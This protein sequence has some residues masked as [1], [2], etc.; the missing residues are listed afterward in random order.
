MTKTC[1]KCREVKELNEYNFA[2]KNTGRDGFDS[3]CKECKKLYDQKRNQRKK[4]EISKQKKEYYNKNAKTL[5]EK[6]LNYY[7][8]NKEKCKESNSKWEKENPTKRRL[9]NVKSRTLE[10]GAESTLT[11]TE[12]NEINQYFD[13]SCAYCGITEKES[14]NMY[15]EIL[16]HE[17]VIPLVVGGAYSYGNIVPSCRSCNSSKMN[18]DFYDWYP[19][20]K[21]YNKQREIKIINYIKKSKS[22]Y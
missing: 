12:W 14:L 2:K 22:T 19:N 15:G 20:S 7:S 13:N 18:H 16:H 10:Y 21:V 11:E 6:S 9:I 5:K 4:V 3:Q 17:H 1:S 8:K